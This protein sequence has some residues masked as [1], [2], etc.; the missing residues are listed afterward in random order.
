ME[1]LVKVCRDCKIE[2]PIDDF[3][4]NQ[5]GKDNR[6]IRR[7]VC[8]E[9]RS[10]KVKINSKQKKEFDLVKP[11]IGEHFECPICGDSFNRKFK[12]D[13]DNETTNPGDRDREIF[14]ILMGEDVVPRK[15]FINKN[16]INVNNLD[17]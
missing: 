7:P 3:E 13:V 11:K 9:C 1:C 16:A 14:K 15:D 2:K 5:V 4:K 10:V 17:I 8:K 6:V 12:N